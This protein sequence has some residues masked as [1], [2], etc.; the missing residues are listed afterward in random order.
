MIN[1]KNKSKAFSV[2][3]SG[4]L[5]VLGEVIRKT[6]S[7]WIWGDTETPD[8]P[9]LV[10]RVLKHIYPG[11]HDALKIAKEVFPGRFVC[12]RCGECCRHIAEVLPEFD[13]GDGV[14]C[15][16]GE[17]GCDIYESRP[18][19]CRVEDFWER[20]LR[21]K[22]SKEDWYRAN[23]QGCLSLQSPREKADF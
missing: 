16:L 13:T 17:S 1:F 19:V 10:W 9:E 7:G 6:P 2:S 12:T 15:H 14:C 18:L 21:G 8:L 22:I 5:E 20:C 3:S 11:N 4:N 23:Y